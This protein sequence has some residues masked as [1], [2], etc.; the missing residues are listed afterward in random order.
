[1]VLSIDGIR[2]ARDGMLKLIGPA[3]KFGTT[4]DVALERQAQDVVRLNPPILGEHT[5]AVLGEF[6]YDEGQVRQL[7]DE[8]VV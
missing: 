5:E 2:A 8:G 4:D 7:R 3:V 1:M 6:G